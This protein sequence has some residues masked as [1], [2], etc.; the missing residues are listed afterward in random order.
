M[1]WKLIP[2]NSGFAFNSPFS[3]LPRYVFVSTSVGQAVACASVTQWAWVQSL[4]GT[5]SLG[6]VFPP[7]QDKCQETLGPH[8]PRISFDH[9]YHP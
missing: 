3:I 4:V 6:E 5:S 7:L 1:I 8:G 2:W 9:H